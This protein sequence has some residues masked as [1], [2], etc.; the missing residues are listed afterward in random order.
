MTKTTAPRVLGEK[1]LEPLDGVDVEVVGRLVEQQH[2]GLC[3]E[4]A[5]QEHTPSPAAGQ[6]V[7]DGVWRE[8]EVRQHELDALFQPPA[9]ALLELVLQDA[10]PLE[11]SVCPVLRNIERH[12]MVRADQRAEIT[13]PVGDDVED[14]TGIGQGHVLLEPRHAHARLQ[15]DG[16]GV[17]RLLARYRAEQRALAGTVPADDGDSLLRLDEQRHGIEQRHMSVGDGHPVERDKRHPTNVPH[18]AW[19]TIRASGMAGVA[20]V[21][22]G[23]GKKRGRFRT[24]RAGALGCAGARAGCSWTSRRGAVCT[25]GAPGPD[26]LL[27]AATGFS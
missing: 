9:V 11:E 10:Q 26:E 23:Y 19:A 22:P 2:I 15:P 3:D 7:D 12:V 16:P 14:G 6:R 18:A 13:E 27:C 21:R 25:T 17:R 5:R 8:I 1:R 24:A 20:Q 4:R